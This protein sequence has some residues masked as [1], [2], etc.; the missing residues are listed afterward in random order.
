M[1]TFVELINKNVSV[2][3]AR[4]DDLD[5]IDRSIVSVGFYLSNP[6][7]GQHPGLDST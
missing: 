2:D 6:F 5:V 3:D 7:N 4:L 1:V